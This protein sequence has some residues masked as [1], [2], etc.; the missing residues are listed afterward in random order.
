MSGVIVER[1][2]HVLITGG[3]C[4][5]ARAFSTALTMPLSMNCPFLT[6]GAIMSPFSIANC[7]L[8]IADFRSALSTPKVF[9]LAIANRQSP[10]A[11]LL[12]SPI[13]QDHLLRA[14]VAAR[15]VTTRR[16]APRRHRVSTTRSLAFTT[17]VR[18]VHRVHRHATNLRPQTFPTRT[19]GLAERN[20]LVLDVA[21]LAHRRLAN[22][23]HAPH[24]ARRHT[25]LRVLA[26]LRHEL[27]KR[28]GGAR[29]LP[30]FAGSQFDVVNLRAERNIDQWQRVARQ[31]VGFGAAHDRLADLES[32]RCDD[33][34]LLAVVVSDQRD[35]R[36][37]IRIVFDL[38]DAAGHA[39]LVALEID[40]AIETLVTAAATTHGDAAVV[41]ASRDALLRLEQRL[42]RNGADRQLIARQVSLVT[43]RCRCGC[44]FLDAHDC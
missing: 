9:Q 39:V 4:P 13:L 26:F 30:A 12:R 34:A 37:A 31:N 38:R 5:P 1:R 19:S 7:R 18:M 16:L 43:A 22:E 41:V 44:K 17:T 29:H 40:D 6:E 2:D 10:I 21:D 3:R 23:R 14:L 8:P 24:F 32:G 11:T 33:V 42:L 25:Q 27:R 28:S 36:R 35:V 15:L 20:V